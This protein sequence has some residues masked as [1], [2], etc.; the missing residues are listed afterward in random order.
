MIEKTENVIRPVFLCGTRAVIPDGLYWRVVCATC[1]GGGRG[2]RFVHREGAT[3]TA[4]RLSTQG[5]HLCG[6]R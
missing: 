5:C 3:R 2:A 4:V 6:A 1:H